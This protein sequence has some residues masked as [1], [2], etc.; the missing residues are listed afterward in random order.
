M[1]ILTTESVET[2]SN[3]VNQPESTVQIKDVKDGKLFK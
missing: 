2:T 3:D 1:P